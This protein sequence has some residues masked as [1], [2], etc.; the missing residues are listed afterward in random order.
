[1]ILDKISTAIAQLAS[2]SGAFWAN[3]DSGPVL[4]GPKSKSSSRNIGL[5]KIESGTRY[6]SE[7]SRFDPI[8]KIFYK[9]HGIFDAH[10]PSYSHKW[11]KFDESHLSPDELKHVAETLSLYMRALPCLE[12]NEHKSSR[13][14]DYVKDPNAFIYDLAEL[15]DLSTEQLKHITGLL[16]IS[17][18]ESTSQT[19]ANIIVRCFGL[20]GFTPNELSLADLIKGA[21]NMSIKSSVSTTQA[22]RGAMTNITDVVKEGS[23]K[24]IIGGANRAAVDEMVNALGDKAPEFFHTEGG[25]LLLEGVVPMLAMLGLAL[26]QA[27]RLPGVAKEQMT[28]FANAALESASHTG[29]R[30][31]VDE[32][33]KIIRPVLGV[34]MNGAQTLAAIDD[35][36]P[37]TVE[38][39]LGM[40]QRAREV[41]LVGNKDL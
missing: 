36:Q 27:D 32:L 3:E 11:V 38:D 28:N 4:S 31:G 15:G 22:L 20:D 9:R 33:W 6:N 2:E 29:A 37:T 5:A 39:I 1:M 41:E 40:G 21:Q 17:P 19:Q 8:S 24:G 10:H 23:R 13:Y 12:Q 7:T 25:K 16:G 34:Y 14:A 35:K 18:G 30:E 26:P